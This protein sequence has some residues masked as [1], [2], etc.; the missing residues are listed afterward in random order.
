MTATVITYSLQKGG[1]GKT[2]TCGLSAFLL[3]DMGYKVLAIDMD[4]QGN[5]TQ[6]ISGY[7]DLEPFYQE[8]IKE[9]LEFGDV[10]P[11]IKVAS[12]NL[13]YVAADD[14]LVLIADYKGPIPKSTLLRKAIDKVIEEYDFILIDTPPNLS[15]QTVN[16][17]IAS[18]YVVIMF[19]T[20]KF[21]YN[22]IPR[23]M[24]S[25]TGARDN[26]NPNLKIA[27]ILATLSDSRRNDNKELLELIKEE[28]KDLVFKTT[29]PRRAAIGRLSVYGFFDNPE[30][31]Q[32]TEIHRDFIKELLSRVTQK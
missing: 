2:T 22:A 20:A 30:L 21:S 15:I 5:L 32:A 3:S 10:D 7:D 16:A 13:H 11:F 9:A 12:D 17:L 1:V 27:G 14:Y 6:L 8:T 23:F 29:I 26:G 28:Y 18:D 4:S 31:R 19:E 24:D 25:I